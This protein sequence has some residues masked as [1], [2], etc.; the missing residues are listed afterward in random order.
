LNPISDGASYGTDY[1]EVVMPWKI[2]WG[3]L[4]ISELNSLFT[5]QADHSK[6]IHL[7]K[8]IPDVNVIRTTYQAAAPVYCLWARC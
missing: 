2:L 5:P 7:Q 1:Q 8:F 6:T 4:F 3:E